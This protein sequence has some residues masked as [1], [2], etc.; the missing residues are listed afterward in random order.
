MVHAS[1]SF[2]CLSLAPCLADYCTTAD[3]SE[4][5]PIASSLSAFSR[6]ELRISFLNVDQQS[7]RKMSEPS[8]PLSACAAQPNPPHAH[9]LMP[10]SP[11]QIASRLS[12]RPH[13]SLNRPQGLIIRSRIHPAHHTRDAQ[14]ICKRF[15]FSWRSSE[16]AV[17]SRTNRLV[18]C[19]LSLSLTLCAHTHTHTQFIQY[20]GVNTCFHVAS[21]LAGPCRSMIGSSA[22]SA[23]ANPIVFEA[24]VAE[25]AEHHWP[26]FFMSTRPLYSECSACLT[27][28]GAAVPYIAVSS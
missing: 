7:E 26:I 14:K 20:G 6:L 12:R 28:A 23:S 2:L 24:A 5:T 8:T 25:V 16:T 13:T 3:L 22:V 11:R 9:A 15:Y 19:S 18:L 17:L 27:S 4:N 1:S 10:G 21:L